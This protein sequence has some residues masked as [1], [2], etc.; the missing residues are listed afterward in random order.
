MILLTLLQE[1][2]Y[3]FLRRILTLL[4][5][6]LL[7]VFPEVVGCDISWLRLVVPPS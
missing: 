6:W 4:S 1:C 5:L 2:M 3:M 7:D